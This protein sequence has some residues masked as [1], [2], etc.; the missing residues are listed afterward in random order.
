MRSRPFLAAAFATLVTLAASSLSH[1]QSYSWTHY[2]GLPPVTGTAD[3]TG[4]SARF[5]TPTGV[6]SDRFATVY[7]CDSANHTIRRVNASGTVTTVAGTPGQAGTTDGLAARFNTPAGLAFDR[8]GT[9]LVADR[10]N[11]TI[12]RIAINGSVSTVAGQ[13]GL[14]GSADGPV[15]TARL[16]EPWGLAFD[17]NGNLYIVERGNS[18]VRK[19]S[20]DGTLSTLAGT[21]GLTGSADGT[22][23]AARFNSPTA[24]TTDSSGNLFVADTGNAT[25]RKL[26]LAGVVTTHA[27]TAGLTGSAN[28]TGPAARFTTPLGLVGDGVGNIYVADAGTHNIR[29]VSP[30]GA[31]GTLLGSSAADTYGA[32]DAVGNVARFLGPAGLAIS[33]DGVLYIADSLNQSIR[34]VGNTLAVTTVAGPGGTFGSLDGPAATAR[35]NAPLGLA[36]DATGNLYV[37]DTR[38][39][40]LRRIS[41]SGT[42]TT[43]AGVAGEATHVDGLT[44]AGRF[45]LPAAVALLENGFV[46]V[47]DPLFHTVRSTNTTGALLTIGGSPNSPGSTDGASISS[48][49]NGATGLAVGPDNTVYVADT[50]NHTIRRL[51]ANVV[52]TL[53]GLPATSGDADGPAATARFNSPRGLALDTA[54]NLYIADTANHTIR[55]LSAAGTVSTIAGLAGTA[56]SANG[57]AATARFN[58][59]TAL[60]VDRAGNLFVADTGNHLVRQISPA[61]VVTTIG[62]APLAGGYAEGPAATARFLHPSGIAVDPSGALYVLQAGANVVVKGLLDTRP[63]ITA[64]PASLASATGSA[65]T[66]T[67][68]ATGG[69]L[70]YQWRFNGT[71]LPGATAAAYTIPAA[72]PSSNGNY[73]VDVTNSAGSATSTAATLTAAPAAN[74]GRLINLSVLTDIAASGDSFTLGYVVGGNASLGAKPL[75]IRATGPSLGAL[76][77]PATLADPKLETFAGSTKTGENDNWGGSAQLTAALA[78]VGAFPYTGPASLDSA[79]S[80]NITTRDNSVAVAA[81]GPGTGKVIAEVYDATPTANFS[82][83]TPRLLNVSVRKHLG[84]GLTAGFVLGGSAPT[85]VLIRAVGPGLAAFGVEGTVA[86]PQLTLFNS[87]STRIDANDNWGGTA[88]LT[89]AFA[90]VGAFALPGATSRDAALL[91]TL[92]PGL[93]SVEVTASAASTS[94][95]G[96]PANAAAASGTALVEV[97]E[98]P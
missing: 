69:G 7:V 37:A 14:P 75:V 34:R 83:L 70:S 73:T 4:A 57:P 41:T 64:P 40:T 27:G 49:F 43:V 1:A 16:N 45:G 32:T 60:A 9:L 61:G 18:T 94:T 12:R 95:P 86:D 26:T 10:L 68:T 51:A 31:V 38:N 53:A 59:P 82:T 24:L 81:V 89:A 84:A 78:A 19:L 63:V 55:R 96:L 25:L 72:G 79:V 50:A 22:G 11:H 80:T 3:G 88:A 93:Y 66:L 58:A 42:V 2:A 47:T 62:G 56:G 48:R 91:V 8:D 92:P 39:S 29:L 5:N 87:S 28:G 54:G 35:F 98:V 23:P 97:Y 74:P 52:T 90:S 36:L 46:A 85:K 17:P 76:G 6:A 13:P 20:V 33:T 65:T 77:V 71:A 30:D 21:A 67:V 44:G 15:T